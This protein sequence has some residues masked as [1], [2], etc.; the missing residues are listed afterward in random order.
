MMLVT[1]IQ[2]RFPQ[3]HETNLSKTVKNRYKVV[4]S[5]I[6]RV[7]VHGQPLDLRPTAT[8]AGTNWYTTTGN[9]EINRTNG[10]LLPV[11]HANPTSKPVNALYVLRTWVH[12]TQNL[13]YHF[14]ITDNL[15]FVDQEV[16]FFT[17]NIPHLMVQGPEESEHPIYVNMMFGILP[18]GVRLR[19]MDLSP[20]RGPDTLWEVRPNGLFTC[21]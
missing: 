9:F 17:H 10:K 19:M 12:E 5:D 16:I 11:I 14:H 21:E 13:Q 20:N 7:V 6:A 1:E 3:K 4:Y 15:E 18:F 2:D 8:E